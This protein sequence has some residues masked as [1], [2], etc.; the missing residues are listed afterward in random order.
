MNAGRSIP[1]TLI[2]PGVRNSIPAAIAT[3]SSGRKANVATILA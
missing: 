3:L 2:A 1:S